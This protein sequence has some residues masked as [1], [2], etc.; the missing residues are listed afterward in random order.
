MPTVIRVYP[1]S[2]AAKDIYVVMP[3]AVGYRPIGVY[4]TFEGAHVEAT[5]YRQ[6]MGIECDILIYPKDNMDVEAWN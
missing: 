5:Q 1:K 6:H 3:F 2:E 4:T